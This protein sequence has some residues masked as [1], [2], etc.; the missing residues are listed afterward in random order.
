MSIY[1]YAADRLSPILRI[2]S[3][4][5]IAT[6]AGLSAVLITDAHSFM[7]TPRGFTVQNDGAITDVHPWEAVLNPSFWVTANHVTSTAIMTGAFAVVS[8]GA[9]K[10]AFGKPDQKE[11]AY[12]LKGILIALVLGGV[13]SLYSA[14]NGHATAQNLHHNNPEKL[15]AAEGLFVTQS[16]APLAVFGRVDPA[17]Q[18]VIG[19]IKIPSG[20]SFLAGNSFNTV[21]RGLNDFPREDWPPLFVHS[22]FDMMVTIGMVLI[23]LSFLGVFYRFI[24]K[25]RSR[26]GCFGPSW[27]QGRSPC[28]VLKRAGC[29]AVQPVSHGRFTMY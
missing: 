2:I 28:S 5:F 4:F 18:E 13:M 16:H 26:A 10:L 19:G 14:V 15:A 11:A 8:V 29:S 27:P 12:H 9:Y 6:G 17:A 21:V 24:R 3:M 22:M 1:V 25:R 7:N 23:F 20:L